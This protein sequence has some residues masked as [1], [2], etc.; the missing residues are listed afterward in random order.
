MP[1]TLIAAAVIAFV[2]GWGVNGWRLDGA[3]A[4]KEA[5]YAARTVER[6]QA[7]RRATAT[8]QADR[9]AL[10]GQIALI[11]R[12]RTADL[13]RA[14][15]ETNRLRDG[16]RTGTI[17]LRV[18]AICPAA[19]GVVPG[20]V[21]GPGVD[22]GTAPRLTADAESAY[23]ALRDGIEAQRVQLGACVEALGALTSRPVGARPE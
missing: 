23:T 19:P 22:T 9:D 16:I 18:A 15:D 14:Q 6:V 20:A 8:A 2:A 13:K 3:A 7:E 12:T 5:A 11:D 1:Y 4:V 10:T 17:G 21:P